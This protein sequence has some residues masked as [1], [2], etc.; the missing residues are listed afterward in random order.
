MIGKDRLKKH[1]FLKGDK[2][3]STLLLTSQTSK[4]LQKIGNLS[5][6][7]FHGSNRCKNADVL[8]L[9]LLK[10]KQLKQALK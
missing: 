6:R 1:S 7:D 5:I 10:V 3:T 8:L 4:I 2:K 9:V